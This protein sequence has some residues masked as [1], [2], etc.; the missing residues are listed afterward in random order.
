MRIT[1]TLPWKLDQLFH[2]P[3]LKIG[4]SCQHEINFF[5]VLYNLN[6]FLI[7]L[8][9]PKE[10][11]FEKLSLT[12][13][14]IFFF[15]FFYV[16]GKGNI[17]GAVIR[18]VNRAFPLFFVFKYVFIVALSFNRLF[19]NSVLY[20]TAFYMF[21]NIFLYERGLITSDIFSL[22]TCQFMYYAGEHV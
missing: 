8:Y 2:L 15:F 22:Q 14:Q 1:L 6:F 3:Q 21:L 7:L 18:A 9:S 11:F 20:V 13:L 10:F 5:S 17:Q 19:L 4:Y 12:V 16:T